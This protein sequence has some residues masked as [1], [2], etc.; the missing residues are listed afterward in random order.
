MQ[1]LPTQEQHLIAQLIKLG[2]RDLFA[3]WPAPGTDDAGK[4]RLVAQLQQL[5][6]HYHK[7][8]QAYISNAR[9]LLKDSRTGECMQ[10][11]GASRYVYRIRYNTRQF[12]QPHRPLPTTKPGLS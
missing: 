7:G 11:G 9:Q 3:R 4:K 10:L 8:L 2:Q 1:S 12:L 5:D 6:A